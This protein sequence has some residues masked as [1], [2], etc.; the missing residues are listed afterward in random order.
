MGMVVGIILPSYAWKASDE[1][2]MEKPV[3]KVIK[4]YS[5]S[6][7]GWQDA[8]VNCNKPLTVKV[9]KPLKCPKLVKNTK[10]AVP[11]VQVKE[12]VAPDVM[13]KLKK[14]TVC[15]CDCNSPA[16]RTKTLESNRGIDADII[17]TNPDAVEDKSRG[18]I[19][20]YQ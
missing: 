7:K 15:E 18:V 16:K 2:N 13:S 4:E 19:K 14:G 9:E 20:R 17:E 3:V 6:W 11:V 5:G 8:C 12:G 10:V 1:A